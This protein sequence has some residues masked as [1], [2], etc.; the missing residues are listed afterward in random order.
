MI[1]ALIALESRATLFERH[2]KVRLLESHAA[3]V[4]VGGIAQGIGN[5]IV[6]SV[7]DKNGCAGT[8]TGIV[9]PS[10]VGRPP[11]AGTNVERKRGY[12][13]PRV[14]RLFIQNHAATEQRIGV[15]RQ[16]IVI[17]EIAIIGVEIVDAGFLG[18][19]VHG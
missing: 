18:F 15:R 9:I 2:V 17:G 5:R 13:A 3:A 16:K 14:E 10:E 4:Q 6:V 12:L 8:G 1:Q 11:V 19:Q 7:G